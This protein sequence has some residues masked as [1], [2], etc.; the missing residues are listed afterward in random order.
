M[1]QRTLERHRLQRR[2]ARAGADRN[3]RD[4]GCRA[5]LRLVRRAARA[6]RQPRHR[7]F[8]QRLFEPELSEESAV[9]Q[10]EDRSRVRRRRP[11]APRQP[12]DL[13]KPGRA[14]PR[15]SISPSSPRAWRAGTRSRCCAISAAPPSRAFF[16]PSRLIQINS[17]KSRLDPLW[18]GPL[19]AAAARNGP[20]KAG[21]RHDRC[22]FRGD[23]DLL[24]AVGGGGCSRSLWR[25]AGPCSA[26]GSARPTRAAPAQSG[27]WRGAGPRRDRRPQPGRRRRRPPE[28]DGDAAAPAGDGVARQLLAQIDTD[29]RVLLGARKL[30]LHACARAR[31]CRRWPRRALGNPMLFYALARYNNIAVPSSVAPGQ[32]ILVPGRR[33][34]PPPPRA[35]AADRAARAGPPRP[36]PRRRR[37]SRPRRA[38]RAA[39]PI[40]PWPRGCAARASPR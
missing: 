22:A 38:R 6:R 37:P 7:R 4:R 26:A 5:H 21:C 15:A 24:A 31:P 30:Q 8:R 36:A 17:L 18:R 27:Q 1:I 16:F 35:A 34:A 2:R 32:T 13:P 11:S 10:A 12:G 29:P 39:A 20:W 3:R 28:A 9:R 40:R 14:D 33:P 25:A 23:S 19:D